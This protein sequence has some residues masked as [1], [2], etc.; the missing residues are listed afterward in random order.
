MS[1]HRCTSVTFIFVVCLVWIA[2]GAQER[3]STIRGRVTDASNS[4]L[5]GARVQVEPTSQVAVTD[6]QGQF[7][8]TGL[9][10]GKYTVTVSYVGFAPYSGDVTVGSGEVARLDATLQVG[11][12]SEDVV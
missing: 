4:I 12:V 10:P 3:K 6:N 7:V 9:V 5:Q 8:I 1:F 11:K 2:A